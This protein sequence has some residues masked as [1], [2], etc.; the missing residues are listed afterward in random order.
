MP[1]KNLR[2]LYGKPL[3]AWTIEAAH[4]SRY[5]DHVV[6][7]TDDAEIA[8]V[9]KDWKAEVPFLRP[10]EL[11]TD[12]ATMVAVVIHALDILK[13]QGTTFDLFMLLQPT[14]PLRTQEDIDSAV[15]TIF[16]RNALSI[17]SVCQ[18]EHHPFYANILTD[19]LCL[20]DFIR[21]EVRNKNRQELP[22]YYRLNGA[23]Y[24]CF[25]D[26]FRQEKGFFGAR[27]YALVM[28]QERSVDIDSEIDFALSEAL[29]RQDIRH[30]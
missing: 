5:I 25:C 22:A 24:L 21:P 29:L 12:T 23:L 18:V 3:I 10:A 26:Q 16:Q 2:P 28:P 9:A 30:V 20:K 11:A 19:D 13:S 7:S 6:I 14:S 27:T 17:I 1:R 4:K 15:E 8:S